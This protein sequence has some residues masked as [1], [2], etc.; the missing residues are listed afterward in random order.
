MNNCFYFHQVHSIHDLVH[1]NDI[2]CFAIPT[3][4]F[5]TGSTSPHLKECKTHIKTP[6][7]ILSLLNK[8]HWTNSKWLQALPNVIN[9]LLLLRTCS[10]DVLPLVVVIFV[11]YLLFFCLV[12]GFDGLILLGGS[13]FPFPTKF[14]LGISWCLLKG[15][16]CTFLDI[17][18]YSSSSEKAW[19]IALNH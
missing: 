19:I 15:I 10:G 6:V 12:F 7:N 17:S 14:G 1:L 2:L 18:E 13:C 9:A 3:P 16:S 5:K 8:S 4:C 11:Y